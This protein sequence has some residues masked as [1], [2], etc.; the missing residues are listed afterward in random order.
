[1][2][3]AKNDSPAPAI[4]MGEVFGYLLTAQDPQLPACMN[5]LQGQELIDA[6]LQWKPDR[7]NT[8]NPRN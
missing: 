2:N 3:K 1:M 6:L 8:P 7:S 4:H 5:D